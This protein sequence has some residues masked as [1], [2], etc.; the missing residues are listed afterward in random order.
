MNF[1]FLGTSKVPLKNGALIS[2]SA[3]TTSLLSL[4]KKLAYPTLTLNHG[5]YSGLYY[6][7]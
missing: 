3:S 1:F 2:L 4:T 6:G 5:L 7:G